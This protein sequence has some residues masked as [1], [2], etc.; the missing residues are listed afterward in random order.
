[1]LK[2]CIFSIIL[3]LLN[4]LH[5]HHQL[6]IAKVEPVSKKGGYNAVVE[7]PKGSRAKYEWRDNI[8]GLVLNRV[9]STFY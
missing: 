1:M 6:D 4:S 5:I 2:I 9:Q 8:E 3:H 7:I